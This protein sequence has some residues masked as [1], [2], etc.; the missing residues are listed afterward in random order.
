[1]RA[2][3]VSIAAMAWWPHD[4]AAQQGAEPDERRTAREGGARGLARVFGGQFAR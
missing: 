3:E 2:D 1:M 4:Y